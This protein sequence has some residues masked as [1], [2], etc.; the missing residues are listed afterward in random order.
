M[1]EK[2]VPPIPEIPTPPMNPREDMLYG[3][4]AIAEFLGVSMRKAFYLLE[5]SRIPCGKIGSQ[6]IASRSILRDYLAK[7]SR[8]QL[9]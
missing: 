2:A 1:T 3:A 5:K 6:W 8:S 7:I 4:K 9:D